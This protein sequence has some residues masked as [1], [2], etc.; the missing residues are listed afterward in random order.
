MINLGPVIYGMMGP[1]NITYV[2]YAQLLDKGI[3][4]HLTISSEQCTLCTI[5]KMTFGQKD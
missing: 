4:V 3:Y 2:S 1:V 5:S